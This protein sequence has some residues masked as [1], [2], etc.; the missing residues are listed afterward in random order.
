MIANLKAK[1]QANFANKR[2]GN[3]D[4]I[5]KVNKG[6]VYNNERYEL[7][8]G[9]M[10]KTSNSSR[11]INSVMIKRPNGPNR[12]GEAKK[13]F[14]GVS[15]YVIFKKPG[16][17]NRSGEANSIMARLRGTLAASLALSF[18]RSQRK[19]QDQQ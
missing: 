14:D 11:A 17:A 5:P 12:S 6:H 15:N 13:H 4:K 2:S 8:Y 9:A 18:S 16:R 1:K 7:V 3:T 19:Y 10:G